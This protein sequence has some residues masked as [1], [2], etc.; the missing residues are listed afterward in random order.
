MPS[1][2]KLR[3]SCATKPGRLAMGI[4]HTELNADWVVVTTNEPLHSALIPPNTSVH[5]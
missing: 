5:H 2:I 4:S 3:L 1:A